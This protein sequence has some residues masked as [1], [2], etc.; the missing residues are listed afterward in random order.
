MSEQTLAVEKLT[1]GLEVRFMEHGNRYFGDYH[2]VK[3][4]V[5]CRVELADSLVGDL[6]SADAL[7]RARKL[8]GDHVEYKRLIKQMAV[9]GADVDA[10]KQEMVRN[11]V[12]NAMSYMQGDDFAARFVARKL[13]EHNNRNR[14]HLVGHD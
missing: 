13:T 1:N 4:T 12:E 3:V 7:A 11:F 9:A 5:V 2:Q 8:F 10:V 14:L 6:L